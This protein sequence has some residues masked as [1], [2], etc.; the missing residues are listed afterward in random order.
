ML[1]AVNFVLKYFIQLM[2]MISTLASLFRTSKDFCN[3]IF[4]ISTNCLHGLLCLSELLF[5]FK[6]RKH[7]PYSNHMIKH[8]TN[9]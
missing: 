8:T 4:S 9:C 3:K 1:H 5:V 6:G 7:S 2:E